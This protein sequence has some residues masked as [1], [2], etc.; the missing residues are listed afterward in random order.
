M[1][2]ARHHLGSLHCFGIFQCPS[3]LISFTLGNLDSLYCLAMIWK[4]GEREGSIL[5]DKWGW[6]NRVLK[7]LR[8]GLVWRRRQNLC[9][10]DRSFNCIAW[11]VA[12]NDCEASY[13]QQCTTKRNE[14]YVDGWIDS[15]SQG[16]LL[17][18]CGPCWDVKAE[19]RAP[20]EVVEL[21]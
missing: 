1:L 2:K 14:T 7:V 5:C 16:V 8:F 9:C 12:V 6:A 13:T 4:F 18:Q 17:D 15:I 20:R 11:A 19:S 21:R 10:V 3:S